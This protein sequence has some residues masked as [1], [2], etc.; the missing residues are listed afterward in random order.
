MRTAGLHG[1][2]KPAGFIPAFFFVIRYE[3]T[4]DPEDHV[5]ARRLSLRPRRAVRWAL[6]IGGGIALTALAADFL[7]GA[8]SG[9]ARPLLPMLF[10]AGLFFLAWYYVLLPRQVRRI[11]RTDPAE[12]PAP[13]A[14][15]ISAA[16]VAVSTAG[17]KGTLAWDDV[18]K[19]KHDARVIVLFTA[20]GGHTA[21][22]WRGFATDIDRAA[23]L[24]LIQSRLGAPAN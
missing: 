16:G 4:I 23:A 17:M 12:T 22:P 20:E 3:F 8:Q 6:W 2:A 7:G 10:G 1:A 5:A 15:E 18:V 14:G 9:R 24:D 13:V 21:I 11:Y 19:W